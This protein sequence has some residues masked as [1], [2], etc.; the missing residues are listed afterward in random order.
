MVSE[1]MSA[2]GGCL[3]AGGRAYSAVRTPDDEGI[4]SWGF[5]CVR[6]GY[7]VFRGDCGERVGAV[8]AWCVR[9][10]GAVGDTANQSE[11][12]EGELEALFMWDEDRYQ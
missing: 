11:S 8:G 5:V 9:V 10:A 3:D 12:M 2:L 4:A 1:E 7:G 6:D